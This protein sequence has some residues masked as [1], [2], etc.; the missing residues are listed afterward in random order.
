MMSGQ[1]YPPLGRAGYDLRD[2]ALFDIVGPTPIFTL[3]RCGPP[4]LAGRQRVLAD[5]PVMTVNDR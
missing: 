5:A 1:T 3:A 4:R 2:F